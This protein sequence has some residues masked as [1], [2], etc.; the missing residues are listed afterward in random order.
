MTEVMEVAEKKKVTKIIR[1][2]HELL[3]QENKKGQVYT[4]VNDIFYGSEQKPVFFTGSEVIKEAIRRASVGTSVAYPITP[5]TVS[6][7]HLTLP[8]ICSV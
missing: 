8:T 3:G 7:T 4:D 1:S 6:Y 5:Q 2:T